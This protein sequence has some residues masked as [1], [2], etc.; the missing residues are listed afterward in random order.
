[1][2][3]KLCND[4]ISHVRFVPGTLVLEPHLHLAGPQAQLLRQGCLLPLHAI[5]Q[6]QVYSALPRHGSERGSAAPRSVARQALPRQRSALLVTA[7][8]ALCRA[9]MHGAAQAYGR[10]RAIGAAKSVSLKKPDRVRFQ[11]S[12]QKVLKLKKSWWVGLGYASLMMS[13]ELWE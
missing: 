10:T 3:L 9:I 7:T 6:Q 8:S 5:N 4:D 11:I 2:K 1:M 12:F 13:L